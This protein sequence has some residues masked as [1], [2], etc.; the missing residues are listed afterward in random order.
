MFPFIIELWGHNVK[1][2]CPHN[3]LICLSPQAQNLLYLSSLMK[4]IYFCLISDCYV[5]D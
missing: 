2:L 1:P 4:Y 5:K 3:Y